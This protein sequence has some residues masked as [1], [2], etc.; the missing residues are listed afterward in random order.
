M[1]NISKF[2]QAHSGRKGEKIKNLDE[3]Q[4]LSIFYSV[5]EYVR[6]HLIKYHHIFWHDQI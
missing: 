2:Q 4:I 6:I 5:I 1:N 3:L